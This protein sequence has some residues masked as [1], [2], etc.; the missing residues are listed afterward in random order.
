MAEDITTD[1]DLKWERSLPMCDT[2]EDACDDDIAHWKRIGRYIKNPPKHGIDYKFLSEHANAG[3]LAL[4]YYWR[5][6]GC[7]DCLLGC[8]KKGSVYGRIVAMARSGVI[9]K[10]ELLEL[11]VK[12]I[13][14]IKEYRVDNFGQ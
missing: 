7:E 8:D 6:H 14:I 10:K 1:I 3:Y 2:I 4:C 13:K 12:Q 9:K 11:I 5:I